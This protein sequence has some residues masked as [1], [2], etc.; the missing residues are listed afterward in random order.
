VLPGG[1]WLTVATGYLPG[2][3]GGPL[4]D[5]G[6]RVV[7][8]LRGS[9][10]AAP[11]Y[12][13]VAPLAKHQKA[14][15]AGKIV[16]D[17]IPGDRLISGH[18]LVHGAFAAAPD[19]R[20]A[21]IDAGLCRVDILDRATEIAA[22]LAVDA[23]G[24]VVTKR[25]LVDGRDGLCCR[26]PWTL[27]AE[28]LV[29]AKVVAVSAEHDLA[30]LRLDREGVRRIDPAGLHV[31]RWADAAPRVGQFVVV[32]RGRAPHLFGMVAA[33]TG[34]A[35]PP[36]FDLPQ[37]PLDVKAGPKGEPVVHGVLADV[38]NPEADAY[39]WSFR[40]GDVI[41]R[42]DGTPTPTLE[43]Y[44]RV[45]DRLLYTA[46]PDGKLVTPLARAPG[47]LAGEP[48]VVTV[49]R[50]GKEAT[51][52]VTKTHSMYVG[53]VSWN[54]APRSLRRDGFPAVFAHDT[55][56]GPEQCGG[57]LLDLRGR[58]VGLNIARADPTRALAIPTEVL[59][60]VVG[61]LRQQAE[62]REKGGGK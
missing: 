18:P 36:P 11:D 50:E 13:P 32:P 45:Y 47:S 54:M 46:G 35:D 39:R 40:A 30:L 1:P 56:V 33:E 14:M 7:G 6:G 3:S 55:W 29:A 43:D 60:R 52:R 17:P 4:F 57:P 44:S 49:R 31:P 34:R 59:R 27:N 12:Q 51:V 28:L 15:E 26:L 23:D 10:S 16:S 58:V 2:D 5:L 20:T 9:H 25:T 41:T 42:L 21:V 38:L 8:V 53:P 19:L 62:K 48:V 37:L 61:E 22:G 24:W